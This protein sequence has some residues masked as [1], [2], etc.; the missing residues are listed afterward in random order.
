MELKEILKNAVELNASDVFIMPGVCVSVKIDGQVNQ[1]GDAVITPQDA[2]ALTRQAYGLNGARG[3]DRIVRDGDDDFSLA[4]DGVGRFRCNAYKQRGA[5]SLV[6]RVLPFC[7]P[8]PVEFNIPAAIIQLTRVRK[9]IVLVTGAVGSGKST[10]L[11]CMIDSVNASAQNH[12]ITIEDPIEYVHSP[13]HSI[14]SQREVENDT[15][16][17]AAALRAALRQA[18]DVIFVGEMRDLE[19]MQTALSAAETGQLVLSTLHTIGAANTIDRIIDVFPAGQQAQIRTQLSMT[20]KAVVSQQL[21][22]AVNGRRE[23]AFEIMI[24]NSAIQNMIRENKVHQ[25]DSVIF[26]GA[27]QGMRSM[28]ADILRLYSEGRISKANAIIYAADSEQMKKK[29]N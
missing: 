10:T 24:T 15:L 26:S 17:Y 18:P 11:A 5:Y 22:P 20:L 4:L 16:S 2:E 19:T 8:D 13:K 21:I 7:I 25:M 27:A 23:V 12:I 1:L 28:D 9:G 6:L 3:T 14:I 29:L